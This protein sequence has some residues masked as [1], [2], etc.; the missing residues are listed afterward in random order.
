METIKDKITKLYWCFTAIIHLI[1]EKDLHS[2]L[3]FT[4]T[5]TYCLDLDFS[6][7]LLVVQAEFSAAMQKKIF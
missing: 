7:F 1:I 2:I 6:I 4:I 5:N 3:C